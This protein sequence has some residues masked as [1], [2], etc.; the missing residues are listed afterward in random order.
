MGG[1]GFLVTERQHGVLKGEEGVGGDDE[2]P[3]EPVGGA[4]ARGDT[5]GVGVVAEG[6]KEIVFL[7]LKLRDSS[8]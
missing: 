4:V 3:G 2:V 8:S 1:R 5:E 6:A 7:R